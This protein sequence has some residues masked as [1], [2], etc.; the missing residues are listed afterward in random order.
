MFSEL[1]PNKIGKPPAEPA[2]RQFFANC[3]PKSKLTFFA[4]RFAMEEEITMNIGTVKEIKINEN[5][6]GIIPGFVASL[7]KQGHCVFVEKN[8]GVGSGFTDEDYR[9]A[10]AVVSETADEV[11]QKS[12]MIVKVKEPLKSEYGK[13]R[14]NQ[15]LFTYL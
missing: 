4:D 2:E 13:I 12:D 9:K 14:P 6:V 10:G 15:I 11:W 1:V 3:E 8:A 7:T 5:R